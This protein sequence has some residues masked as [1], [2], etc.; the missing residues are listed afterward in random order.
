M[1]NL[2]TRQI[3]EK[4]GYSVTAVNKWGMSNRTPETVAFELRQR[5]S[6]KFLAAASLSEEAQ[7]MMKFAN[8]L[9]EEKGA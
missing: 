5:A 6:R 3:A 2:T 9:E 7:N 1:E 8:E 4:L